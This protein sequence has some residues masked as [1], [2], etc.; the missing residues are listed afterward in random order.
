MAYLVQESKANNFSS[1]LISFIYCLL[2]QVIDCFLL[3]VQSI[4]QNEKCYY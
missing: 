4:L 2:N 3:L 1:F